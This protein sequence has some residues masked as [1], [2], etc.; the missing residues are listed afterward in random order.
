MPPERLLAAEAVLQAPDLDPVVLQV[1]VLD[2]QH[3]GL[4]HP[5]AV[6]VDDGEERA[7]A[8]GGDDGKEPGEFVLGEVLGEACLRHDF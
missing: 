1:D 2:R 8:R 4:V 5:E 6:V 3:R 7:I